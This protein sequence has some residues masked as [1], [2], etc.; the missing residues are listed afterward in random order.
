MRGDQASQFSTPGR[1]RWS[2]RVHR[3]ITC[4]L[5][6]NLLS[7]RTSS[8]TLYHSPLLTTVHRGIRNSYS[9][10]QTSDPGYSHSFTAIVGNSLPHRKY[11]TRWFLTV[12][13]IGILY[14]ASSTGILLPKVIQLSGP[15][16]RGNAPLKPSSQL[17]SSQSSQSKQ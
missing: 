9:K 11:F 17:L 6:D 7:H 12:N 10:P 4:S 1:Q 13:S 8:S 3:S 5:S 14:P 2:Q 15:R 16:K